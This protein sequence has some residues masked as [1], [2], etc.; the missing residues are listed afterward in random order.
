MLYLAAAYAPELLGQT[1]EQSGEIDMLYFQLKEVKQS[2]TG[3]C[4]VGT[5]RKKLVDVAM[6]KMMPIVQYLGKKEYLF[7]S[8]VSFMDF[9]M[10]ELCEF[11]EWL[12]EETYLAASKPLSRYIKRMKGIK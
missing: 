2:I 5:D 9:Y 1:P 6:L 12:S 11:V 4:Y 8:N 3:P 7:G 10:L